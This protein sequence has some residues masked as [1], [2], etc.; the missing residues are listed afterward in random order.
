[1]IAAIVLAEPLAAAAGLV[2]AAV[3]LLLALRPP[4]PRE[5]AYL[6]LWELALAGARWRD[7]LQR[8]LPRLPL[9]LRAAALVLAGLAAAGPVHR[10]P[11]PRDLL[12]LVDRSATMAT[13]SDG[14]SR[15]DLARA[16]AEETLRDLGPEDRVALGALGRQLEALAAPTLDRRAVRIALA[17]LEPEPVA[18]DLAAALAGAAGWPTQVLI[19]TDAA[20]PKAGALGASELAR[21][22]R[23]RVVVVGRPVANAGIVGLEV[24]DPFPEPFARISVDVAGAAVPGPPR[25]VVLERGSTE[26]ARAE[27]SLDRTDGTARVVLEAPRGPGG[28]L[29]ARLVPGDSFAL[30]DDARFLLAA[31]ATAPIVLLAREGTETQ[32]LDPFLEAAARALAQ[33]TGAPLT[34]VASEEDAPEGAVLLAD[35]GRLRSLPRR[36]ILFGVEVPGL[37]VP[38]GGAGLPIRVQA[39]HP[40]AR[41]L[42][43]DRLVTLPRVRIGDAGDA[44]VDGADG[45][46]LA[47]SREGGARVVA[48]AFR[49]SDSNLP[50][51]GGAFPV[52]MRRAYAWVVTAPDE[53]VAF[54]RT[55][56]DRTAPLRNLPREGPSRLGALVLPDGR[57]SVASLL[58]RV[59]LDPEPA[60]ARAAPLAP[61]ET[62]D[63]SLA[64]H[65]ASGAVACL[66]SALLAALLGRAGDGRGSRRRARESAREPS[67][68]RALQGH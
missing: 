27:V 2:A 25:A 37:S 7:R 32:D 33:E 22:A 29:R 36:A 57:R 46:L 9:W 56:V 53:T 45:P 35:G 51:L 31:P 48:S 12:I 40:L 54:V 30:D 28:E 23:A 11:G 64:L 49:L 16:V 52:W 63:R 39:D 62:R 17:A 66:A 21:S 18:S 41:G 5:T 59:A 68:P 61:G 47:A 44:V 50:V 55:G 15:L 1:M 10:T 19:V 38:G 6:D 8:I 20:G 3:L 34:L 58:A 26:V 24:D 60:A 14:R 43:L 4:A 67:L 13:S 42:A 65:C